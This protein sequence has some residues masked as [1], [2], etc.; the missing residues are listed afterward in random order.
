[1]ANIQAEKKK[2]FLTGYCLELLPIH[3][4]TKK[5]I[6]ERNLDHH[7]ILST[8]DISLIKEV[9]MNTL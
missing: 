1:M 5:T 3:I 8:G 9:L 7:P 6:E 2:V 4:K